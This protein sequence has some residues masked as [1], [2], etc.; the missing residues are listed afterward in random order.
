MQEVTLR[1]KILDSLIE[2][3]NKK[4]NKMIPIEKKELVFES[5]KYSSTKENIW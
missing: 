5:S 1:Q 3:R 2:I 4:E